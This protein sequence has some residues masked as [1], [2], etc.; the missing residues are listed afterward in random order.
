MTCNYFLSCSSSILQAILN[1]NIRAT[2]VSNHG[3]ALQSNYCDLLHICLLINDLHLP[4]QPTVNI[5]KVGNGQMVHQGPGVIWRVGGLK[6][7]FERQL[8]F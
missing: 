3:S 5:R 7:G 8:L 6:Y 1:T 4:V 2:D